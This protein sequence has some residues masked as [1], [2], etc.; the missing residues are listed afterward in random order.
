MTATYHHLADCGVLFDHDYHLF[1]D[2]EG[3]A[4]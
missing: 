2:D 1:R 3:G 4:A